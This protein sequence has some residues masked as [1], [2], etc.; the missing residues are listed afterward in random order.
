MTLCTTLLVPLHPP[1][2]WTW[3]LAHCNALLHGKT[4]QA[5][6]SL[7]DSNFPAQAALAHPGGDGGRMPGDASEGKENQ[8]LCGKEDG[9]VPAPF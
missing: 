6:S 9:M 4:T 5:G 3:K 2:F 8:D 7:Q 1:N